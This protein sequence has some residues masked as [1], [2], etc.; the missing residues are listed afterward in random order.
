MAERQE[1]NNRVD[2]TRTGRH[3]LQKASAFQ[4]RLLIL[5]TNYRLEM[6]TVREVAT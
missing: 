4:F 5:K 3:S 2:K 1:M 6:L